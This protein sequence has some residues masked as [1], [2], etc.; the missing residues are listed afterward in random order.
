[1]QLKHI[2]SLGFALT[3]LFLLLSCGQNDADNHHQ[4]MMNDNHMGGESMMDRQDGQQGNTGMM[5]GTPG[6]NDGMTRG[7][8]GQQGT[9]SDETPVP[10]ESLDRLESRERAMNYLES[11]GNTTYILGDAREG[12]AAFEYPV[13]RRADSSRV[14]TLVV[15]KNTGQVRTEQ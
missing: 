3:I 2:G 11:T 4:D 9:P 15:D 7:M 6:E 1:M 8:Q 14:A 12:P 5:D 13:L 10:P